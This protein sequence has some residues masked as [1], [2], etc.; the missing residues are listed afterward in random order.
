MAHSL[1]I[2]TTE[3]GKTTLAKTL[4]RKLNSAG[5]HTLILDPLSD[6]GWTAS[7]ITREPTEFIEMAKD[8]R[9]CFLFVDEAG[10]HC[11]THDREMHWLA[12]QS[13]HW[14]HSCFFISQR[15]QQIAKTI[16][17]Q[18]RY[19]YLF[20]CSKSDAKIFADEWN[21]EL[22]LQANTLKQGEFFCVPRFGNVRKMKIF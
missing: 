20:A 22:I 18:C 10:M 12:T 5:Y 8:S 15:G 17:E 4:S 1:I 14:G 21:K 13:R 16:R 9:S 19:L 6:P 3:S 2:G 11:G 7:F